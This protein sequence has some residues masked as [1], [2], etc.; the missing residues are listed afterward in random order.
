MP[1]ATAI[2]EVKRESRDQLAP[3]YNVVL[4]D[5]DEHSYEYVIDMLGKLFAFSES[6]AWNHAV[7]V[8]T[9]GRTVVMTCE[10]LEAEFGRDQIHGFG[11]DWRMPQSKGSMSAIVEAR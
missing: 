8:D 9:I 4:L 7:E 2:P 3:L 6:D 1:T 11:A 10:L 5:D